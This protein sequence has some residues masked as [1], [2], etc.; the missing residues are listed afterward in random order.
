MIKIVEWS[1]AKPQSK[2]VTRF[3]QRSAF[4]ETCMDLYQKRIVGKSQQL[5]D[6]LWRLS[7]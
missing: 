1:V 5:V 3:L 4:P 7:R 2:T 6:S